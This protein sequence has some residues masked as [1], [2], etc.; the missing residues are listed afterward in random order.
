MKNKYL[1][2]LITLLIILI[3]CNKDSL[4]SET[5]NPS[6]LIRERSEGVNPCDL[7]ISYD[8]TR[9]ESISLEDGSE[10][11]KDCAYD[12]ISKLQTIAVTQ[13]YESCVTKNE[14]P[15]TK[16]KYTNSRQN[17]GGRDEQD[18]KKQIESIK[19]CNGTTTVTNEDG[20]TETSTSSF[21]H[22]AVSTFNYLLMTEE[23]IDST[24]TAFVKSLDEQNA[25]YLIEGDYIVIT[26]TFEDGSKSVITYDLSTGLFISEMM[27]D[28]NGDIVYQSINSFKCTD[29]GKLVI[30]GSKV[31]EKL[32]SYYCSEELVKTTFTEYSN[33]NIQK[34]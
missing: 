15:C 24:M 26:D 3:G 34:F 7:F 18:N 2:C 32:I 20:E 29:D 4:I 30:D 9:N 22:E 25:D 23:E 28:E 21:L 27:T 17:R 10:V 16:I 31:I 14:S 12:L 6:S 33:I 19:F 11:P 1:W 5:E 13:E 8:I